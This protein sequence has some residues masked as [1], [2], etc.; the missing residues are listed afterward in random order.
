MNCSPWQ[1]ATSISASDGKWAWRL[2]ADNGEVIATDGGQGY[3]N[4]ADARA[5]A[6]AIIG[7]NYADAKKTIS[8]PN[9]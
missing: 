3:E 2:R 8:R 7:G 5:M 4:E 6:D 1:N 9:K